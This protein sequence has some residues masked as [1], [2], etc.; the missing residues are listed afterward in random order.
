MISKQEPSQTKSQLEIKKKT[1][2]FFPRNLPSP[3]C[4]SS[5]SKSKKSAQRCMLSQVIKSFEFSSPEHEKEIKKD[6]GCYWP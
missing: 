4:R 3:N 5:Y 6:S 2:F 1:S